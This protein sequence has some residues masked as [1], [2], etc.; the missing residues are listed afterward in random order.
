MLN[1]QLKEAPWSPTGEVRPKCRLMDA[2]GAAGQGHPAI[3]VGS[4]SETA[5]WCCSEILARAILS[6]RVNQRAIYLGNTS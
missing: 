1:P 3:G 2:Y 5:V 4:G 6:P